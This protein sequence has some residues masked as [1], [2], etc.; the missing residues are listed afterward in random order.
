MFPA[1]PQ[2]GKEYIIKGIT[3]VFDGRGFVV[4]E[5]IEE[6]QDPVFLREKD[7]FALKQ[8]LKAYTT[9]K[10]FES[11][12]D[13]TDSTFQK[14]ATHVIRIERDK[15]VYD[16]DS[17]LLSSSIASVRFGMIKARNLTIRTSFGD[18]QAECKIVYDS[19]SDS[20]WL[21]SSYLSKSSN[22]EFLVLEFDIDLDG[23]TPGTLKNLAPDLKGRIGRNFMLDENLIE[24]N[25]STINIKVFE[26]VYAQLGGTQRKA[27][28]SIKTVGGS[29][30][31]DKQ[32]NMP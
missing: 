19:V 23:Y 11:F 6:E 3:Y 29:V 21:N 9:Q 17:I 25:H 18:I 32:M 14:K 26:S 5:I 30:S 13:D 1:N 7:K 12:V 16:G 8:D 22:W 27:L 4:K 15:A 20:I 2:I 10:E 31:Y 24:T 28:E